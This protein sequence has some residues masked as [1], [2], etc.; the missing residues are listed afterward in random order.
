MRED[1]SYGRPTCVGP[2]GMGMARRKSPCGLPVGYAVRVRVGLMNILRLRFSFRAIEPVQLPAYS[3]SAWR[4]LFGHSL[5]AL[6]CITRQP[7]CDGCPLL[8]DCAY[9]A[10]FETP[11]AAL[12]AAD[13]GGGQADPGRKGPDTLPHPFVLEPDLD[14]PPVLA[15]GGPLG[16][17]LTLL[18]DAHRRLTFVVAAF[19][20]AGKRGLGPSQARLRL[21]AVSWEAGVGTD[22]WQLLWSPEH[23]LG[24]APTPLA[25]PLP[26]Q[27]PPCPPAVRV[28]LLTPL[29]IKAGGRFPTP[30]SFRVRDLLRNLHTRL[31]R[32]CRLYGGDASAF[33]W[34]RVAARADALDIAQIGLRW[35]DW[36]RW[37]NRQGAHQPMG[38]L[39]GS[40]VLAG[41][42]LGLYWPALWL[43]QWTH[44]GK[45]T[46]FGLG[47]YRL[48]PLAPVPPAPG[49]GPDAA[50]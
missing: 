2:S 18:G 49:D 20:E 12:R 1:C 40:F 6:A 9:P 24:P 35:H 46:A 29:R 30:E 43:G 4:G 31:Q 10:L 32:L 37:S 47:G 39:V 22:N 50:G 38:G 28:R 17:G 5:R 19:V 15:P 27:L 34:G 13:A 16:L 42:A 23:G 48:E 44:L 26:A 7:S 45:G 14:P 21:R 3:G 33:D 36:Q 8:R 41:P 11:A 25:A